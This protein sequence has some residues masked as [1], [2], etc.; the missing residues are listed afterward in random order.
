MSHIPLTHMRKAIGVLLLLQTARIHS[1]DLEALI[2]GALGEDLA[3]QRLEL[4]LRNHELR[5]EKQKAARGLDITLSVEG[6]SAVT[7]ARDWDP[8]ER[9]E[10]DA[11]LG[12]TPTLTAALGEPI[13]TR[14]S[15]ATPLAYGFDGEPDVNFRPGVTQPLNPLLGWAPTGAADMEV[16]GAVADA[17]FAVASRRIAVSREVLGRIKSIVAEER[18]RARLHNRLRVTREDFER[19]T[20]LYRYSE[21]GYAFQ[22]MDWEIRDLQADGEVAAA[23]ERMHRDLL[24]KATGYREIPG[25]LPEARLRLPGPQEILADPDA[26]KAERARLLA[27][28]RLREERFSGFPTLSLGASYDVDGRR[29][30]MTLGFSKNLYDG[31][32]RRMGREEKARAL[33]IAI[34]ALA[35]ARRAFLAELAELTV[36]AADLEKRS[37]SMAE[38]LRLARLKVAESVAFVRS[39]LVSRSDLLQAEWEL[40]D[41]EYESRILALDRLLFD[42]RIRAL[43][44]EKETL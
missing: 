18:E 19:R 34:L 5:L 43:I 24:E 27:E 23:R 30:A 28:E 36:S 4:A 41:V 39:G 29:L 14:L 35:E 42:L 33:E 44:A 16:A 31:G 37:R 10:V 7:Y 38:R 22:K 25:D 15:L 11:A 21:Q 6:G 1:L 32:V 26:A 17:R 20:K 40:Q 9:D 12:V 2:D 13:H 8:V 3:L